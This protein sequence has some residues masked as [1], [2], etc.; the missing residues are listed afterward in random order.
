MGGDSLVA[1][2]IRPRASFRVPARRFPHNAD[3][4]ACPLQGADTFSRSKGVPAHS[5]S[6]HAQDGPRAL[7]EPREARVCVAD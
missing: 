2:F 7:T 1:A 6:E 3:G 5:H 4:R